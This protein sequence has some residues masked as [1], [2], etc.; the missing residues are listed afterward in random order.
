MARDDDRER[1][2]RHDPTDGPRRAGS[3]DGVRK[4]AVG[5]KLAESSVHQS[6]EDPLLEGARGS[7]I[8]GQIE[9]GPVPGEELVEFGT[10]SGVGCSFDECCVFELARESLE[11]LRTIT[12]AG[13]CDPA[14]AK[15]ARG[16]AELPEWPG[17]KPMFDRLR[18]VSLA[19]EG[20][21]VQC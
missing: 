19:R 3:V 2:C 17:L 9:A 12:G 6:P 14:H 21:F 13:P 20:I 1:V 16:D 8:N 11:H 15:R 18:G 4:V 5:E 7:R 10:H